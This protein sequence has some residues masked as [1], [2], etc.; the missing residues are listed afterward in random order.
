MAAQ[1]VRSLSLHFPANLLTAPSL[2]HE[3][4]RLLIWPHPLCVDRIVV[5][6]LQMT[7]FRFLKGTLFERDNSV[8]LL[9]LCFID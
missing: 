4:V 9:V 5:P 2:F 7:E 1:R 3:Y 6:V 8:S